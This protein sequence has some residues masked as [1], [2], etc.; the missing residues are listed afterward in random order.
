MLGSWLANIQAGDTCGHHRGHPCLA[1][2]EAQQYRERIRKAKLHVY[3]QYLWRKDLMQDYQRQVAYMRSPEW[4][5][6]FSEKIRRCSAAL[7]M[8]RRVCNPLIARSGSQG[9][10]AAE[11]PQAVAH[12]ED[13][14]AAVD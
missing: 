6:A 9:E 13:C 8:H 3:E 1:C 10:D 12:E 2:A 14:L 4:D 11:S 7:Y 5:E